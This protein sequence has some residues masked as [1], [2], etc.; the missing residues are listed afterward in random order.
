MLNENL[1][2]TLTYSVNDVLSVFMMIKIYLVFRSL[3]NVSIYSSPRAVRLCMYNN[4]DHNYFFSLKCIQQEYPLTFTTVISLVFMFIFGFGFRVTEGNL[5][6]LNP[7]LIQ[8]TGFEDYSTSLWF[9]FTT[10]TSIGYGDYVPT[11][12]LGRFLAGIISIFGVVLNSFL[13]VALTE[14]LKMKTG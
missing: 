13:V 2:L 4:I 8:P 10:M 7:T 11:S 6:Y 12:D 1:G 3:V 14:Y 9:T 5:Y